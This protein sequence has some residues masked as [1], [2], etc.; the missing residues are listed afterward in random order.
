M[1]AC[2]DYR[3]ENYYELISG[4]ILG[5]G[6]KSTVFKGINKITKQEVAIK[7]I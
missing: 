6:S 4:P 5:K 3:I 1:I 2:S 7:K